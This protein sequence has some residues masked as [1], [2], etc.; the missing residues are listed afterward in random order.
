M[1]WPIPDSVGGK[2]YNIFAT[3]GIHD[4]EITIPLARNPD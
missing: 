4:F 2:Q 1:P 3:D